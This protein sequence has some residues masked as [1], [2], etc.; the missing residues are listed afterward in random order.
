MNKFRYIGLFIMVFGTACANTTGTDSNVK[1]KSMQFADSLLA[2]MSLEEKVGQMTNLSLMAL[3]KGEFWDRRDTVILDPDKMQLYL[4][5]HHV[6]SIQN[7]GTYP[8]SPAEWR[9]NIG[10]IQ[11]YVKENTR[12]GIPVLYGIDAVHGANYTE[13]STMSPH[14]IGLAATRNR[15]LVEQVAEITAYEVRASG[16]PWNYAPVLDVAKEPLWGRGFETFGEDTY[17]NC[18][19]GM[20]MLR[21]GS[22]KFERGPY[23]TLSC[24][25]HFLAYG[26]PHNGKDRAPVYLP[27]RVL[28]QDYLPPFREAV[29]AGVLTVMAGS[30]SVNGIPCHASRFLLTDLLKE[31]LG[32]E[33]FVISDWN[34]IDNLVSTHQV[35]V[36]EKEA[37]K[38]AVNAGID[39]CMEPYDASFAENLLELVE[40]GEVS[41]ERVD[42]AVRRIIFVK[43]KIGL[44][45]EIQTD[46]SLYTEFASDRFTEINYKAAVESL[47]LLKN[48]DER[49]PLDADSKVLVTGVAAHSINYLNGAWSRTWSGTDTTFNDREKLTV[50]EALRLNLGAQNVIYSEGTSYREDINT[51][52]TIQLAK[53]VDH[54]VVCLG[55][56]P[57]TEKPSDID[58]LELPE[59]QI[60]LVKALARTGKPITLVLVE[61]RPRIIR[62]IEPEA[63]AIVLAYLPGNEGGRAIAD[64]L[65]GEVNPS[66]KLPFTYPKYSGSIWAYD[67]TKADMR[68]G[69]FGYEAF[70]PQFEFGHGLS[71]TTFEYTALQVSKDTLSLNEDILFQV[72]VHNT[73]NREG[74]ETVELYLSDI[75]ASIVPKVKQLK[76]FEK[77]GLEAGEVQTISFTLKGED[78]GFVNEKNEW[79][80][81][82]GWF[83]ARIGNLETEFYLRH[84]DGQ[85]KDT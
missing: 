27:E 48:E 23:A 65:T 56:Q 78:L 55:E 79:T 76:G 63:S 12:H 5:K 28:R 6:G 24:L 31:E 42:D 54:I 72:D 15:D 50:L 85:E 14:Q 25:K 1:D 62:E 13:G 2:K 33:G 71:F 32:F 10:L 67:H 4:A 37:V 66:G 21:G 20:A 58:D 9:Q 82:P 22:N 38:L 44:F 52:K 59:A 26:A 53:S 19:L 83:K 30:H 43:H 60:E 77:V 11:D 36:D 75:T 3:A 47:T 17:V 35:A 69:G 84:E 49:L 73:G 41:E 34:D 29:K 80:T 39:M 70:D 46:P 51:A 40:E 74:M 68:D 8:F 7:L 61:G 57:A 18:E 16:I 64:V 45:D 81:E